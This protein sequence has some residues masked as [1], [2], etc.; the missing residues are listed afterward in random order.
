MPIFSQAVASVSSASYAAQASPDVTSPF[1]PTLWRVVATGAGT[2]TIAF[3]FDGLFDAGFVVFGAAVARDQVVF[4][5]RKVWL[6]LV[7]GTAGGCIVAAVD[8]GAT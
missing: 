3:S 8:G 2:G 5:S 1:D 7:T 6:R 4:R